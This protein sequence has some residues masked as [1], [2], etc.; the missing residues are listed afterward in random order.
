MF[1]WLALLRG[2]GGLEKGQRFVYFSR[3]NSLTS[4][5]VEG[6][7][8]TFEGI[9]DVHGSDSLPLGVLGVGDSITDD[10][11]QED[12]EDSSGFFVDESGDTLHS[13][14][15]S[16]TADGRLGDTLDVISQYLPV[17]LG[18]PL[19]ESLSSLS[20]SRHDE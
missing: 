18:T 20:T 19:S 7:S 1:A 17:A 8:L 4:E 5:S 16:Q 14:T 15:T 13:T 6:T 11:F 3:S 10:I 2:C 12:L 9:D